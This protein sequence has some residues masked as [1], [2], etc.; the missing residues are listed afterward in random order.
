MDAKVRGRSIRFVNTHLDG[1]CLPLTSEIQ[2]AQAAQLIAEAGE[3]NLP[4]VLAGD[5]NTPADGSGVTYNSIAAA[6]FSDAW[7]A[8]H[9]GT[10]YTCCQRANLLNLAS[11]LERRIDF[12]LFRGPIAALA[13]D[14]TGE[15]PADKTISGWWASDH[16]G[17]VSSL[18][19]EE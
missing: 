6:G 1:D 12:V 10:G 3:T 2:Q 17:V 8:A 14:V 4:M 16:A 18:R 5:L 11:T 7:T 9:N 13:V 19:V 15:E